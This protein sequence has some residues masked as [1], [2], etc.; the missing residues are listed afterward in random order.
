MQHLCQENYDVEV[1]PGVTAVITGLVKSG[2]DCS[3]FVFEGFLSVNKK[4]RR[5]KLESLK[6]E[7]RTIVFYE[8]PHKLLYT[9]KDILEYIGDRNIC[10]ARELTKIHEEYVYTTI[11]EAIE[12]IDK[13]GIKGEIVL[14]IKGIDTDESIDDE[15][16]LD[17]PNKQLVIDLMKNENI[18][19]NEAI[20]K[21]AKLKGIN[22]NEVYKECFDI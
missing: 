10:I 9:L 11:S 2:L 16:I 5:T 22:K 7:K 14:I 12:K 15:L 17:I 6:N 20:K 13:N 21:V 4:Q 18:S 8:A 1:V 3:R 19:K